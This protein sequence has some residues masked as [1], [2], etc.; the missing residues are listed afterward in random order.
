MIPDVDCKWSRRK[1]RN[2]M[3][4]GFLDSFTF[5]F[6]SIFFIYFYQLNDELDEDKEKIFWRRKLKLEVAGNSFQ[7]FPG[8]TVWWVIITSL[9]VDA[10]IMVSKNCPIIGDELLLIVW[11]NRLPLILALSSYNS[12][13]SSVTPI[14]LLSNCNQHD[15][16]RRKFIDT[17][18]F[19]KFKVALN[20]L[21]RIF[22]NF[23]ISCI[24]SCWLQFDNK[25]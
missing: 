7:H 22:L 4:F 9:L 20:P 8:L 5:Y 14:F 10:K 19:R 12:K 13:T 1:L 17:L 24:L 6:I 3:D 16:M 2:G 25:K 15:K 21:R 11:H 18:N 23:A